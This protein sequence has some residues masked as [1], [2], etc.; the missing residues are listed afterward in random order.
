MSISSAGSAVEFLQANAPNGVD[1]V[2]WLFRKTFATRE[3][4]TGFNAF[5]SVNQASAL[6]HLATL[7]FA[8]RSV[9]VDSISQWRAESEP[10][11]LPEGLL[12]QIVQDEFSAPTLDRVRHLASAVVTAPLLWPDDARPATDERRGVLVHTGGMTSPAAG[13]D[14]AS[15][16]TSE[17]IAPILASIA[18]CGH[19]VALLGNADVFRGLPG[20]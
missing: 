4:L 12:A 2:Q 16:I 19:K 14:L 20:T 13:M 7:G 6:Q 3:T 1:I 15:V 5:I 8:E 11:S 10:S 17:L 9:F 18:G